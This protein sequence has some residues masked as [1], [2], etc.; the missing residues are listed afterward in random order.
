MNKTLQH[1]RLEQVLN[2]ILNTK[3]QGEIFLRLLE[4]AK[5]AASDDIAENCPEYGAAWDKE[6][7]LMGECQD[8]FDCGLFNRYVDAAEETNNIWAEEMY[9]RGIQDAMLFMGMV[10]GGSV[11]GIT[12]IYPVMETG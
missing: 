6:M 12:G 3:G 5:Q 4:T 2:N 9:L 1:D 11:P 10:N 7:Q 8:S